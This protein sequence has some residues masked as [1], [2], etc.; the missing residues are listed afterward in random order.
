MCL[1]ITYN[2][3]NKIMN[4]K[5][6]KNAAF[7]KCTHNAPIPTRINIQKALLIISV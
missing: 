7:E 6:N 1:P 4:T 3:K 5:R 2:N